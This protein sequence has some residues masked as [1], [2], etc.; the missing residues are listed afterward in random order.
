MN[1]YSVKLAIKTN[2]T[3]INEPCAIC[4]ERM[5]A[6]I[7]I[8]IFMADNYNPV[9]NTCAEK[10]SPLLKSMVDYFYKIYECEW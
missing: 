8:S 10:H 6:A 3:A 5:E 2:S 9:C 4:G 1:D 7:P